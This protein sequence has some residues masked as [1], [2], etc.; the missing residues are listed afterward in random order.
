MIET[1]A[2]LKVNG[3]MQMFTAGCRGY[4]QFKSLQGGFE[5]YPLSLK[6]Y[7]AGVIGFS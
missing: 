4:R 7:K 6:K 2:S 5:R 1:M 3:R